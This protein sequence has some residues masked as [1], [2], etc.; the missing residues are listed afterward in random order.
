MNFKL[1]KK[2]EI[3]GDV[4]IKFELKNELSE[5]RLLVLDTN[6]LEILSVEYS[7][8]NKENKKNTEN[9]E[10]QKA[11]TSE[12]ASNENTTSSNTNKTNTTNI[13]DSKDNKDANNKESEEK[14]L[15]EVQLYEEEY[16]K[17]FDSHIQNQL[18]VLS[19]ELPQEDIEMCDTIVEEM[20]KF[21]PSDTTAFNI[22]SRQYM[23]KYRKLDI[24]KINRSWPVYDKSN[25]NV[26][27]KDNPNWGVIGG[28]ASSGPA[29]VATAAPVQEKPKEEAPKKV[30]Y[31][32]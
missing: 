4:T 11:S 32:I 20:L 22:F 17:I 7:H 25:I 14:Y 18:L 30:S 1:D 28:M 9:K 27:P 12:S 8:I 2:L 19:K 24:T 21:K 13:K 3:N 23:L 15:K 5:K 6:N 26:W 29:Q 10:N 16:Q 31:I